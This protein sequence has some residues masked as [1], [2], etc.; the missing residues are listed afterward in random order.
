MNM[1]KKITLSLFVLCSLF[2]GVKV[3]NAASI[4]EMPYGGL[5]TLTIACTCPASPSRFAVTIFDYVQNRPIVL[6]YMFPASVLYSNYN[7][8][9]SMYLL[10]SY[11]PYVRGTCWVTV[12]GGDCEPIPDNGLMGGL[13]GT[14][15][16]Q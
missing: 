15:T 11:N 12:T 4:I 2:L 6:S 8:W 7:I 9:S 16:S 3:S 1:N 5:R 13:P 10:G 14:G